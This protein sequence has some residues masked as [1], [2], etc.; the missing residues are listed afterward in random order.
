[1]SNNLG[2]WFDDKN[3]PDQ[4]SWPTERVNGWAPGG[5]TC[6]C[7][8]GARYMGDKRSTQCFPCADKM[9]KECH[10][11]GCGIDNG[12]GH[13]SAECIDTA[14]GTKPNPFAPTKNQAMTRITPERLT[15]ITGKSLWGPSQVT[16]LELWNLYVAQRAELDALKSQ[17]EERRVVV[18]PVDVAN[19]AQLV[20][21]RSIWP[22]TV[23]AIISVLPDAVRPLSPGE[24]VA[25]DAAKI[26]WETA[27]STVDSF[28]LEMDR[29]IGNCADTE[30][31]QQ[32]AERTLMEIPRS[33]E[34]ALSAKEREILVMS[35]YVE[36]MEQ[37]RISE[38]NGFAEVLRERD[39]LE[40]RVDRMTPATP[41][42]TVVVGREEYQLVNACLS[43]RRA[44]DQCEKVE[45]DV[46]LHQRMARLEARLDALRT[47]AQTQTDTEKE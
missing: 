26:G 24:V 39:S 14:A 3:H 47:S 31:I 36:Q 25:D 43:T 19:R 32:L 38:R 1:M 40:K 16:K 7:S 4:S 2:N 8:C 23:K 35:D 12:H 15:E 21:G 29:M 11:C 6:T 33:P 34:Q 17:L 45:Q 5:Y 46:K 41:Q 9:P 42:G 22:E 20:T 13:H 18:D 10:F 37:E 30:E 44:I 28:L 27:L